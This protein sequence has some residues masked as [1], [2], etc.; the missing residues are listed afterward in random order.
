[1]LDAI[2]R[3]VHL[4]RTL[5]SRISVGFEDASRA[6]PYFLLRAAETAQQ[7]GAVRIRYADTLGMLDP[8]STFERIA[9][10][11]AAVDLGIEIHAHDDLGLATANTLAAIRAGATHASTTVNG[12][13][14]RAGNAPLEEV[15]MALR[16]V[17]G[18]ECGVDTTTLPQI[19]AL[20]ARAS[21]RPVAA[22]K[23]IVGADVFTHESGIHVD[24]LLKDLRNYQGFDPSELGRS[25]TAVLGKHSGAHAVKHGYEQLG[26]ELRPDEVGVV[27]TR[28]RQHVSR[29]KRSPARTDLLRFYREALAIGLSEVGV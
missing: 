18:M 23:S 15:V 24:G 4:G 22:G 29:T 12:L 27:L 21:G 1:M 19:S 8:F 26:I 25:H 5:G 11:R 17:H 2:G 3:H 10:L 14:E 9:Q 20:V 16:H 28:I 13:G 6:D 7:A